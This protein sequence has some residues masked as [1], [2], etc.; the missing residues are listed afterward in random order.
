LAGQDAGGIGRPDLV[1]PLDGE[2]LEA[3]R[4]NRSAM[5]A[6]GRRRPILGALPRK[7]RS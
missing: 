7:S 3:M 2:V 6:V 4:R 1:G 5:T